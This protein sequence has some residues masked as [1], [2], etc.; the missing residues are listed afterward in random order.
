[1]ADSGDEVMVRLERLETHVGEMKG[2]LVHIAD[3][4]LGQSERMDAGLR[5]AREMH[6]SAREMHE[7]AREM[8]QRM[9]ERLDRLIDVTIK[10]RTQSVERLGD[11]ERR[12][13]R[14]EEHVGLPRA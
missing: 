13:T 12:L 10:D 9:V 5:S 7:S 4:L 11:V 1:M 6:E 3:I 8:Q 14:I 2:T